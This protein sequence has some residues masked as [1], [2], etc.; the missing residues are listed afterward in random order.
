VASHLLD[1]WFLTEIIFSTLKTEAICSSE[2]SVDTQRTTLRH[3]TED[4]TLLTNLSFM[5]LPKS[6]QITSTVP[7]GAASIGINIVFDV[8][9]CCSVGGQRCFGGTSYFHLQGKNS[10]KS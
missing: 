2:T 9:P 10:A 7:E 1:N 4:D 3:I 5:K 6:I 8:A